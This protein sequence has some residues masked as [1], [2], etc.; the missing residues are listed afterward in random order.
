[1]Y[2]IIGD[3]HG[4]A[5]VLKRLLLKLG[6]VVKDG[7]WQHPQ[8]KVIFLGDFVDRGPEQVEVIEIVKRMVEA[9]H[10]LAVMGNHEFNAVAWATADEAK[11][12]EFLRI[13]SSK[14]RHQHAA[15]LH[16]IGEDSIA[17]REAIAWFKTLP[18]FLDFENLRVVHACWHPAQIDALRAH[19]DEYNRIKNEAWPQLCSEGS[20][21]F[22]A[23]ETILKGMEIALPL[24]VEFRDKDGHVRRRT[25]TLWW[26]AKEGLTYRELAMV[27]AELIAQIPHDPVPQELQPGYDGLKPLFIG[28]YWMSGVPKLISEHIVCLDWSVAGSDAAK[29]KLCA[30]RWSGES[31]LCA[32]HL[33]WVVR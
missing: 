10:A 32:D 8:H 29:A 17:H 23:L 25:R 4:Y 12:G 27:P 20:E 22:E 26:H 21:P 3:I 16:Q 24:G 13:H 5:S 19:I 18:L 14:N 2:D 9:G 31:E 30:Y 7:E 6:Y 11:P 28:H 33:V 15:F 1:M